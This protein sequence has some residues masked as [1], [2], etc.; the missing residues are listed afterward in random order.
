M[1]VSDRARGQLRKLTE[2]AVLP[3]GRR[4]PGLNSTVHDNW[5]ALVR[6]AHIAAGSIF[7][8]PE[9]F[10]RTFWTVCKY[11]PTGT[12]WLRFAKI[13]QN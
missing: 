9:G 5:H 13:F 1:R 2:P 6:F 10:I 3:N 7:T 11:P 8:T 4:I 12:V